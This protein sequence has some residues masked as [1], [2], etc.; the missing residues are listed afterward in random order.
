M[1]VEREGMWRSDRKHIHP[2]ELYHFLPF[3]NLVVLAYLKLGDCVGRR[4][5]FYL[6]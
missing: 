1:E 3:A 2:H 5:N 6:S 4:Q